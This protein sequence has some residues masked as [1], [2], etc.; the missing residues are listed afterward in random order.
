VQNTS[1]F[2]V[3]YVFERID[4]FRCVKG[5]GPMATARGTLTT[6][7][8]AVDDFIRNFLVRMG[9]KKSMQQFQVEW[10][11]LLSSGRIKTN[12]VG[13]LPDVVKHNE[14]LSEKMKQLESDV[15]RY[16]KSAEYD[17]RVEFNGNALF[18]LI[19]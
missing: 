3:Q 5:S 18:L 16:R 4:A 6:Q 1:V 2:I 19:F 13:Y 7:P 11:S 8:E 17:H 9:M 10:H 12:D 15:D 14:E